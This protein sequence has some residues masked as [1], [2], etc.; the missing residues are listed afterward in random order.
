MC[1]ENKKFELCEILRNYRAFSIFGLRY[2]NTYQ[3]SIVTSYLN[4]PWS[5]LLQIC[6]H[7]FLMTWDQHWKLNVW[8]ARNY[9]VLFFIFGLRH[10]IITL[11]RHI[12]KTSGPIFFKFV[13]TA[14][15]WHKDV[16]IEQ[17]FCVS[18]NLLVFFNLGT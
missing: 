12:Y 5:D 4:N 14:F 15:L 10:F 8:I 17:Y 13:C 18:R 16:Q 11:S 7:G 6:M 2:F 1:N 3:H 9:C